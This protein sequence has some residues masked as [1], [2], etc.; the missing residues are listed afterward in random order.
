[1]AVNKQTTMDVV[2]PNGTMVVRL[3]VSGPQKLDLLS[4]NT[5]GNDYTY[6]LAGASATQDNAYL[7]GNGTDLSGKLSATLQAI[8]GKNNFK[9]LITADLYDLIVETKDGQ[10]YNLGEVHPMTDAEKKSA[11]T[12]F[13]A[14]LKGYL[15]HPEAYD[16]NIKR[17]KGSAS[18][19]GMGAQAIEALKLT[20]LSP[21]MKAITDEDGDL[22]VSKALHSLKGQSTGLVPQ[23][24]M[25]AQQ[26]DQYNYFN[27]YARGYYA[28]LPAGG[29]AQRGLDF[30]MIGVNGQTLRWVVNTTGGTTTTDLIGCGPAAAQAM[31]MHRWMSGHPINYGG[32]SKS[33]S[34]SVKLMPDGIGK[35]W[36]NNAQLYTSSAD[37]AMD[38]SADGAIAFQ[39]D[40]NQFVPYRI[41]NQTVAGGYNLST[42]AMNGYA[43]GSG[44]AVTP[45]N[46]AGGINQMLT[47]VWPELGGQNNVMYEYKVAGAGSSGLMSDLL[48]TY[49]TTSVVL[50]VF[51]ANGLV[52]GH[53][54]TVI[55][56]HIHYYYTW[57][58][59]QTR[60][61]WVTT[62]D[63]PNTERNMSGINTAYSGIYAIRY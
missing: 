42:G 50:A 5:F 54:D 33:W 61:A 29:F 16:K 27:P 49:A 15:D 55:L 28:P 37:G 59:A 43:I 7:N 60:D 32:S 26:V 36:A 11:Q 19:N 45:W 10:F 34:Y 1:M 23:G 39:G 31:I 58:G 56:G 38:E 6:T 17:W 30:G 12:N 48:N 14:I 21:A 22:D 62:H 20:E 40:I 51:P 53:V 57:Y 41:L 63:Y 44:V 46:I 9:R 35:T 4:G 3:V 18:S 47:A 25:K 2:N 13:Q 8:G 24:L 52:N